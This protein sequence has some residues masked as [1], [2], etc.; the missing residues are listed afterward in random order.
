M[1]ER[2]S[3]AQISKTLLKGGRGHAVGL[4]VPLIGATCTTEL[5][6]QP[7]GEWWVGATRSPLLLLTFRS[8]VLVDALR[9]I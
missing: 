8:A 5:I 6:C 9:P 2:P 4:Y 7:G 1:A 3:V